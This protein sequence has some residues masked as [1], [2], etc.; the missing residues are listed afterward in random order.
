MDEG[1]DEYAEG[2]MAQVEVAEMV[3]AKLMLV[4]CMVDAVVCEDIQSRSYLLA[5][6]HI[7]Q[8]D[9]YRGTLGVVGCVQF[10]EYR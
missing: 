9:M 3:V 1:E 7:L 8:G 6:S 4:L 10:V 2:D 5:R